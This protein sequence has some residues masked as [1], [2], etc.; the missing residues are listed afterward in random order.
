MNKELFFENDTNDL[1]K[2]IA[3]TWRWIDYVIL[4][5]KYLLFCQENWMFPP[6]TPLLQQYWMTVDY[7]KTVLGVKD[8]NVKFLRGSVGKI[9]TSRLEP[10]K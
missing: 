7:K 3:T 10:G 6:S 8:L 5:L 1:Q 4:I 9:H 2:D